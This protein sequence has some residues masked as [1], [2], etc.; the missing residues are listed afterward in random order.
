MKENKS[1]IFYTKRRTSSTA[2]FAEIGRLF[3]M[4]A[5]GCSGKTATPLVAP[6]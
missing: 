2:Y 1:I 5:A 4:K 6:D 3:G